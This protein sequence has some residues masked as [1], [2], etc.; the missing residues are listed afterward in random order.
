[1]NEINKTFSPIELQQ[2]KELVNEEFKF[3]GGPEVPDFLV[4]DS[5][6]IGTSNSAVVV[7]AGMQ[8]VTISESIEDFS[9]LMVEVADSDLVAK[10]LKSGNM[11]FLNRRNGITGFSIVRETLTHSKKS[12]SSWRLISDVG[13]VIHLVEGYVVLRMVSHSVEAIAVEFV[14]EFSINSYEKPSSR[15]EDNLFDTYSSKFE[16]IVV[17]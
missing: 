9:C 16:L 7:S 13:L 4:S 15:F 3:I 10:T 8:D 17:E 2:L 14:K 12:E 1:M 5:F 11:Y 6:V